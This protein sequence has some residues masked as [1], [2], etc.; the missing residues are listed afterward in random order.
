MATD[1]AKSLDVVIE[2]GRTRL[3][4]SRAN[5]LRAGALVPL[6]QTIEEPVNVYAH[7]VL[8][9][10]GEIVVIE[11]QFCVRIT[12]LVARVNALA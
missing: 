12:E 10:R 11:N 4:Q 9:A 5:E 6:D 1:E 7:D 2:L 3:K 8:V